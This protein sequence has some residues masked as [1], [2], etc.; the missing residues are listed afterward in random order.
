[1]AD[2]PVWMIGLG[3]ALVAGGCAGP[4]VE[5]PAG[6]P[7][8]NPRWESCA[9]AAAPPSPGFTGAQDALAAPRLDESFRPVAAVVC[10]SA[11][12]R[13][14]AGGEDLVA[15]EERADDVTALVAT[16]RLPDE[17]RTDDP[18]TADLPLVPWLALLD[19][20]GRWVRPGIPADACGK[21]RR[22]FRDAFAQLRTRRVSARVLA[23]TESDAA[24]KSGCSQSWAD[25]VWVASRFGSGGSA[26]RADPPA[27]GT[28]RRCVYEVPADQRGTGKP[29]GRFQSGGPL[30][31]ATWT[32]V[33]RE[34]S[35]L[36]PA[37]ACDTPASRFAVLHP[38]G[39]AL[40]YLEADGCRRV[41]IEGPA[42]PAALRQGSAALT[43]LVFGQ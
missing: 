24:A 35:A 19:E 26:D 4:A 7:V 6:P 42:G 5:R 38:P 33:R 17:K 11:P 30:P 23:E 10:R 29:A 18:C 40:V 21:P 28:V 12:V 27:G 14:P 39:T 9:V 31:A 36:P 43:K 32:A 37:L 15:A 13:R 22:E 25:M 41:L 2:R 16:L 20:Q 8:A 1:M 3:L 34:L